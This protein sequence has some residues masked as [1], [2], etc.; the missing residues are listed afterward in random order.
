MLVPRIVRR[1]LQGSEQPLCQAFRIGLEGLRFGASGV[2]FRML[3]GCCAR[4]RCC[5][6]RRQ[7][8][9]VRDAAKALVGW[10]ERSDTHRFRAPS[11][12]VSLRSTHPT[13]RACPD[14]SA[15]GRV[16]EQALR[17]QPVGASLL[18]NNDSSGKRKRGRSRVRRR[19]SPVE[20]V[21]KRTAARSGASTQGM[22]GGVP[23]GV[24]RKG[25]ANLMGEGP[26]GYC[27]G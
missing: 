11:A 26:P 22:P 20:W 16:R 12:W 17:T 25:P 21:R 23:G 18:A 9:Q 6:H 13:E 8:L 3:Y 24:Q 4:Y 15:H 1:G 27:K 2:A 10:V 5:A 19:P 7:V 14:I